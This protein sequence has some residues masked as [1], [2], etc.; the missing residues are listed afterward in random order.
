MTEEQL[1]EFGVKDESELIAKAKEW[2]DTSAKAI[3]Y[4][5]KAKER[6]EFETKFK[7]VESDFTN[8][9]ETVKPVANDF[10]AH[11]DSLAK[12]GLDNDQIKEAI[13]FIG[14]DPETMKPEEV[15]KTAYKF[16]TPGVNDNHAEAFYRS[17]FYIDP[18]N[19]EVD[20]QTRTLKEAEL[21]TTANTDRAF[22]K[23]Y[24]GKKFTPKVDVE[25]QEQEQK[26]QKLTTY[27]SAQLPEIV[28]NARKIEGTASFTLPGGKGPVEQAVKY[29]F[30][31]PEEKV[32]EYQSQFLQSAVRGGVADNEEGVKQMSDFVKQRIVADNFQKIQEAERIA[33][34][35]MFVDFMMKEFNVKL[36]EKPAGAGGG[37]TAGAQTG[38][39]Y[40]EAVFK[41]QGSKG[42]RN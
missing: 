34:N 8:Y 26:S 2:K 15:V 10:V 35:N 5:A 13:Q 1:T 31:L 28:K 19:T 25:R 17:R 24:I 29:A 4:E 39:T 14:V 42:K 41:H 6:D 3:E 38:A 32:S 33:T 16:R 20:E 9:K 40:E 23:E 37:G 30:E 36:P 18:E 11:I 22:L 7:T 27:W 12:K 21:I